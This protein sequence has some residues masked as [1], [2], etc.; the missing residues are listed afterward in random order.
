M[1]LPFDLAVAAARMLMFTRPVSTTGTAGL[2]PTVG[3]CSHEHHHLLERLQEESP[4]L[5]SRH[6]VHSSEWCNKVM[7]RKVSVELPSGQVM[8]ASAVIKFQGTRG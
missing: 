6:D 1:V 2:R 3:V 5:C 8:Q 7:C 4:M